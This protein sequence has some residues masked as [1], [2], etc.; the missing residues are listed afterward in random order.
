[1]HS[2]AVDIY[3]LGN[4]VST[5]LC[6]C[7]L[8]NSSNEMCFVLIILWCAE[9]LIDNRIMHGVCDYYAGKMLY[10]CY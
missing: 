10:R 6:V 2:R 1:M 9:M 7:V 4:I 8:L 3:V 5:C